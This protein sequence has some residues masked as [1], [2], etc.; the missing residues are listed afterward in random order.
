[1]VDD[2]EK[3]LIVSNHDV[4]QKV[5]VLIVDDSPDILR[6]CA[7][8]LHHAGF[9]VQT[10]SNGQDALDRVAEFQPHIALLDV[11]LP[12]VDGY[13]VARRLRADLRLP[14]I[15]LIAITAYGTAEDRR[16]AKAAGFDYHLVKP[17]PFGNLLSLIGP[18][19]QAG[20]HL[21]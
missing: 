4:F 8:L 6:T 14:M 16:R 12:D 9:E 5:R 17:V 7:A 1:M 2:H 21:L 15:T 19:S 20:G 13:E 18:Q 3:R 11:G 10:A